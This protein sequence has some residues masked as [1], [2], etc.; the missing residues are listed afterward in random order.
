MRAGSLSGACFIFRILF[1]KIRNLFTKPSVA[2]SRLLSVV[3]LR[4]RMSQDTQAWD[5]SSHT[6]P[7]SCPVS[8]QQ[9][10]HL[11]TGG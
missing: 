7:S 1:S 5:H 8:K 9:A 4:P 6:L 3:S 2:K 11:L 10:A